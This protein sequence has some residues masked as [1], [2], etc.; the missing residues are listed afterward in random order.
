MS[1]LS[2]AP[3]LSQIATSVSCTHLG[4]L[5]EFGKETKKP[6]SQDIS[7]TLLLG[8]G[9]RMRYGLHG[10]GKQSGDILKGTSSEKAM[11]GTLG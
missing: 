8:H 2:A 6:Q 7:S 11:G 5:G 9:A 1:G 3:P 10:R 4:L